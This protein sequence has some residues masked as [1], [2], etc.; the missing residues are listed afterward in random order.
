MA[1]LFNNAATKITS[2]YELAKRFGNAELSLQISDL[3]MELATIK[4]AYADLMN[5]NTELKP[6]SP[7]WKTGWKTKTGAGVV[8]LPFR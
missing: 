2:I 5:T 1:D 6:K 8:L 4:S 7:I 3:Q